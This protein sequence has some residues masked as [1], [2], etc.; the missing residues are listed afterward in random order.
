MSIGSWGALW[1]HIV[2]AL[3]SPIMVCAIGVAI[4][5]VTAV[6]AL[7]WVALGA[8]L[9]TGFMAVPFIHENM[10]PDQVLVMAREEGCG[11]AY[12]ATAIVFSAL[13]LLLLGSF[14]LA[15]WKRRNAQA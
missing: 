12:L 11:E 2:E 9:C 1:I 8:A 10:N 3:Q 14:I 15:Q 13:S 7:R 4:L 6:P 5:S